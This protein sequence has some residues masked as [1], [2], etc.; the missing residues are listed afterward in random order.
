MITGIPVMGVTR[1][2]GAGGPPVCPFWELI[3]PSSPGVPLRATPTRSALRRVTWK[4]SNPDL[5]RT[6]SRKIGICRL[7]IG[8]ILRTPRPSKFLK[9][10]KE[11]GLLQMESSETREYPFLIETYFDTHTTDDVFAQDEA[12]LQYEEMIRLRDL[13]ANTPTSVPYTEDQIM[14]MLESHHKVGS[15]GESGGGEDDEAGADE[16]D[17]GDEES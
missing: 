8:L 15:G 6:S 16:D 5:P 17:D 7:T 1:E 9:P 14:A 10:S 3:V 4:A 2:T 11:H 12:R 13:G